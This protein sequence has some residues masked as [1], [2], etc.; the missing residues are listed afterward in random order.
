MIFPERVTELDT[1]LKGLLVQLQAGHISNVEYGEPGAPGGPFSG[2]RVRYMMTAGGMQFRICQLTALG[3]ECG[4]LY[5]PDVEA[6]ALQ[7]MLMVDRYHRPAP[8]ALRLRGLTPVNLATLTWFAFESGTER[9][10]PSPTSLSDIDKML[11]GA[12][13][14]NLTL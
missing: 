14:I 5:Y 13:I 3:H 10:L 12:T 11:P 6:T 7:C 1:L 8:V 4:G 9:Q 2:I